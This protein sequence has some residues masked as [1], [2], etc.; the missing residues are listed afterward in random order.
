MLEKAFSLDEFG[1][2]NCLVSWELK[3]PEGAYRPGTDEDTKELVD[4]ADWVVNW[5]IFQAKQF[6]EEEAKVYSVVTGN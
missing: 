2:K 5:V 1:L 3:T 4:E 6:A